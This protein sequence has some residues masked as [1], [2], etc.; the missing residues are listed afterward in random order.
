MTKTVMTLE[1]HPLARTFPPME[2]EDFNKLK[3]DIRENG[4]REPLVLHECKILDGVHRYQGENLEQDGYSSS[5]L[6]HP[7]KKRKNL[8]QVSVQ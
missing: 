8:G 6:P 3:R 4:L 2:V 1:P 7:P 5:F